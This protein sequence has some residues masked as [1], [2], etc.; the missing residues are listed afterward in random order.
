MQKDQMSMQNVKI[1]LIITGK[2][3]IFLGKCR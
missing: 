1:A 2:P 3:L